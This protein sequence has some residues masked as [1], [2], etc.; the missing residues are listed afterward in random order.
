MN[1]WISLGFFELLK[2]LRFPTA[3]AIGKY[4]FA[5]CA[6]RNREFIDNPECGCHFVLGVQLKN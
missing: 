3:A 4:C 6:N 2:L 5:T 1:N